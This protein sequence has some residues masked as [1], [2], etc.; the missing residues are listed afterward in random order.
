[1]NTRP[2]EPWRPILVVVD[3]PSVGNGES[4]SSSPSL[5]KHRLAVCA[6]VG[7]PWGF[8]HC[9]M[10]LNKKGRAPGIYYNTRS[11]DSLDAK[12]RRVGSQPNTGLA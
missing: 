1:M 3:L 6:G 11:S 7:G 9:S 5:V 4:P 2:L 10:Q 8:T 12:Q